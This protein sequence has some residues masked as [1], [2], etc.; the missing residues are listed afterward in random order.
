MGKT[1]NE[2]TKR[3][4]IKVLCFTVA[5]II[6]TGLFAWVGTT[7]SVYPY[8]LE[9]VRDAKIKTGSMVI[10]QVMGGET[11]TVVQDVYKDFNLA[12]S[13][14][15]FL[16]FTNAIITLFSGLCVAGVMMLYKSNSPDSHLQNMGIKGKLLYKLQ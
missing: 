7:V 11:E 3:W 1:Y 10:K 14:Y 15:W 2:K 8:L 9:T 12:S 4:N 6:A 13:H 5:V 16:V